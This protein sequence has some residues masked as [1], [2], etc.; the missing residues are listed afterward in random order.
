[1]RHSDIRTPVDAVIERAWKTK[2][3]KLAAWFW[4]F[5]TKSGRLV[6]KGVLRPESVWKRVQQ[7]I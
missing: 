6:A 2:D 3:S 5:Y 1:M 4:H 7:G